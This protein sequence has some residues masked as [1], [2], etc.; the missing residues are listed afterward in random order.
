MD[1]VEFGDGAVRK[2]KLE[3]AWT[4]TSNSVE[5]KT[6]RGIKS[7]INYFIDN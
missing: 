7:G 5:S 6:L 2:A 1:M 4:V 3:M